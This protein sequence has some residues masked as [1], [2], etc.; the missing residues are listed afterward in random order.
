[1][2]ELDN[3]ICT[4]HLLPYLIRDLPVKPGAI[5]KFWKSVMCDMIFQM[6][7]QFIFIFWYKT[8]VNIGIFCTNKPL[9]PVEFPMSCDIFQAL[10]PS[11]PRTQFT[12]Q[13]LKFEQRYICFN[14]DKYLA[15]PLILVGMCHLSFLQSSVFLMDLH[16]LGAHRKVK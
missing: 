13:K 4:V 16:C 6:S 8:A 15:T 12:S 2:F 10:K 5:Q 1:M 3:I 14:I 9:T 11:K 7:S